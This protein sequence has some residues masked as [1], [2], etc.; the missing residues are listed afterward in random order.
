M[1]P[2]DAVARTLL[3]FEGGD[4]DHPN[5][6]GGFT[7]YGLTLREY[8][9][10]YPNKTVADFSALSRDEVIDIVTEEWALRP[11][12]WRIAD[13]WVM[14]AVIDFAINSGPR[15]AT[16]A[17]QRAAGLTGDAVDGLFGRETEMAV[18]NCDPARLF[19]RVMAERIRH[20]ANIIRRD[21]SQA[22]FAGGWFAR[23]ATILEAA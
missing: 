14:W 23:A 21:Q 9:R 4:S 6:R 2:R 17:L 5:D 7:R 3:Q 16:K 22:V 18:A 11:G 19:R 1:T 10:L 20:F 13:L 15:T 8:L 12:Y